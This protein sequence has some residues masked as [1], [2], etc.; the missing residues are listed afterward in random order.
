MR[1]VDERKTEFIRQAPVCLNTFGTHALACVDIPA[2][3]HARHGRRPIRPAHDRVRVWRPA[4]AVGGRE[5]LG[6]GKPVAIED[7]GA[8]GSVSQGK[9]HGRMCDG[10]G[11]G[12]LAPLGQQNH[13]AADLTTEGVE[14]RR[15]NAL[16]DLAGDAGLAGT[17]EPIEDER[18]ARACSAFSCARLRVEG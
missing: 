4:G 16:R 2:C 12:V 10:I 15:P 1:G 6:R 13:E 11:Q 7:H 17:I 18:D 9:R 14:D 3:D 5:K 8:V